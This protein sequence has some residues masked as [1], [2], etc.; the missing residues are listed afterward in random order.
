MRV[1]VPFGTRDPNSR[2]D[3]FLTPD[4]RRAFATAMCRDVLDALADYG[5]ELLVDSPVDLDAPTVV[6]DRPLGAAVDAVLDE[7]VP[8]AIVMADLPLLQPE[9]VDRLFE[10]DADLVFAPG[11]GGGTNAMVVR[12]PDFRTDYH[13]ASIRDHRAIAHEIDASVA[14]LDSFR[15]AT[16]VDERADLAEVLLHSD[17]VAADWLADASIEIQV[18]DGRVGVSR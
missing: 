17:G 11:R 9:T 14:E 12:H 13:G 7:G 16:D 3:P 5:P 10:P 1:V 4:E 6:D 15:F 8:V 2:L 18:Q